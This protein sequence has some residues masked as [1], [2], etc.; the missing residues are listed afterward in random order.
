MTKQVTTAA[1][2]RPQR[3][4]PRIA[5]RAAYVHIPFCAH[6]CG[7]CDF[8]SVA[9]SDHMADRYLDALSKEMDTLGGPFEVETIFI[10]G[11][12]PTRL[13]ARQLDRLLNL[14]HKAFPLLP[15]GEWTVEA[16]PGTLD[17]EKADVLAK[18]GVN[19][20]SLGA[21]SFQP[22]LLKALER[23]HAPEQVYR[24]LELLRPRFPFWSFDLIFGVPGSS[25]EL[26]AEDL[27]MALEL[28]PSHL[29]C[30]GLVFEK[31][32]ALWKQER[33]GIVRPVEEEAER[34][35]YEH[36]IDRL[37][38]EGLAMYEISNFARPGHECRHNLVYWANDSYFG[39]GLG[40]ARYIDQVR[41]S[42]TR[43]LLGYLSRIEDGRDPTGPIEKLEPESR[44]RETAVLMLRRT[45]LGIDRDEFRGRT[46]FDLDELVVEALLRHCAGGLLE[47]DGR[48]VRFSREGLLLADTVLCDLL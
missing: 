6:K 2:A 35:M 41:S 48:R 1:L 39:V 14:V 36:T 23:N 17:T 15:G 13:D 34:A 45:V 22:E 46:G 11:G 40:A 16:N 44:A 19:R 20:V 21:Q 4:P 47:D 3:Q 9:G 30:Y 31:G 8:A 24:A 32:T 25:P 27:R 7:Y 28:E 29:S 33:A 26:W 37:S 10:G 38:S 42:N 43:D 18:G 12:T 5:P